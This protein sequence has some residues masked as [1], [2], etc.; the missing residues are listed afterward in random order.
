M[1]SWHP[2]SPRSGQDDGQPEVIRVSFFLI[3]DKPE[4]NPRIGVAKALLVFEKAC[5][6]GIHPSIRER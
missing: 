4:G 3:A 6:R 5:S 1:A 2:Y